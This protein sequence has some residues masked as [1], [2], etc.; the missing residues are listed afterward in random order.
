MKKILIADS[1]KASLVMTS[2]VFKDHYPG[3]QVLVARSAAEAMEMAKNHSGVDAFVIDFDLPDANG[4]HTAF[5]LK[6]LYNTPILITAFDHPEVT[7]S[8]EQALKQYPDCQS[9]LKKPV[10]PELV[11]AVAQRFCDGKIRAQ[12]RISCRIPVFAEIFLELSNHEAYEKAISAHQKIKKVS[13]PG[14]QEKS[15]KL[16]QKKEKNSKIPVGKSSSP[17]LISFCGVIEDCSLSG[18]KL[19]PQK[20]NAPG[21]T[22]WSELLTS[23]EFFA[24]GNEVSLRL[25]CCSEIERGHDL[26][27]KN[28]MPELE[29]EKRKK[30]GKLDS[31]KKKEK[32][33]K[34]REVQV[35]SGKIVWTSS[36]SGEWCLGVE[37]ENPSFSKRLFEAILTGQHKPHKNISSHQSFIKT[38]RSNLSSS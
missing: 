36:Q 20:S 35:L 14:K 10:N 5:R 7:H 13:V 22:K 4:A 18:V 17:V 6:K 11:I 27:L 28:F 38:S 29:E 3:I 9:W 19:K 15:Q 34:K 8:I 24:S 37:L 33:E 25:P 30:T 16:T 1:S 12:K 2:E 31:K 21:L 23:M 26:E 32:Q